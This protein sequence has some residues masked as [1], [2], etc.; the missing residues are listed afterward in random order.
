MVSSTVYGQEQSIEQLCTTLA[1][2]KSRSCEYEV[3]NSHMGWLYVPP[4]SSNEDA[5]L[6]AVRE[7][8][9]FLGILFPR[10][11]SGI[12]ELEFKEAVAHNKPR[13]YLS[14]YSVRFARELL[15]QYMYT[16][17]DKRVKNPDF[18]FRKTSVFED[19][20]I[21]DMYNEAI[22]DGQPP[23][24]R[25]WAHEFSRIGIEGMRFIQTEFKNIDRLREDLDNLNKV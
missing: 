4:G 22:Q 12:T 1:N 15:K 5:C 23:E 14:H 16:D 10:Y 7:C 9:F 17:Y 19:M 3:I 21:I 8:D 24:K 2:Y 18:T 20:R 11:G 13:G 6:R 25:R